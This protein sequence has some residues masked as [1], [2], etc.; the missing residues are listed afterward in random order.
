MQTLLADNDRNVTIYTDLK[1]YSLMT[2]VAYVDGAGMLNTQRMPELGAIR[3]QLS[4]KTPL[5]C[6]FRM[7]ASGY[8]KDTVTVAQGTILPPPAVPFPAGV[9]P[10]DRTVYHDA[11]SPIRP[12]N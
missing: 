5:P 7:I 3:F 11:C 1:Q 2:I 4:K 9:T 6:N 10:Q 12:F 8:M